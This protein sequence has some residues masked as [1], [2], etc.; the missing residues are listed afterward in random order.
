MKKSLIVTIATAVLVQLSLANGPY[1]LPRRISNQRTEACGVADFNG[2][3]KLDIVAGEYIYLAPD[4]KPVK[5]REVKSD[6]NQEG[7][8]YAD[9]FCNLI[10]DVNGDG[11]P[12]IISGGWF[13]KSNFWFEN[14]GK[15]EGLW[16]VHLIEEMG[17]HETGTL[18]DITG[19]GK[20]HEFLPQTHTTVW[21]ERGT[22]ADG[23]PTMI[24]H[25]ISEERNQLGTGVGDINGDGRPDV[26]RP[27]VWFEAPQDIRKDKWKAH[28]ISL[29]APD[30]KTDHTSVILVMDVNKDG[31]N[32][33]ICS[34][35]HKHGIWWYEQK[36]DAD[37]KISWI[38]HLIDDTWTQAHYLVLADLDGDGEP[39]LVTGKRF[40]AH[41]GSDPDA[42]GKLCVYYYKFKCGANPKFTRHEISLD[43]GIGAGLNI[44][45]VDIDGDG[46][47]D[48]ITT[49]KWGGP[50]IFEN[51]GNRKPTDEERKQALQPL[52]PM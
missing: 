40:M 31:L 23:K 30:N 29:G 13:N 50:V 14:P 22:T 38:Q 12:D 48:L 20:A 9:D 49:G 52:W 33:L 24:R 39:E 5:I 51:V 26:L 27:D 10:L 36:R 3:G 21:Y 11:K 18:E 17:N 19:D 47:I 6:V 34:S 4:W 16:Q 41:N 32:D 46:D 43:E 35:A 25:T 37:G 1:F 7:K 28:P 45:A 42:F 8:G 15:S 44:V 2:D